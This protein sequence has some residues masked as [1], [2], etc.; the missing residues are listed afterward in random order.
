MNN[1]EI[2]MENSFLHDYILSVI[3]IPMLIFN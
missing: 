3:E 1:K 2:Y